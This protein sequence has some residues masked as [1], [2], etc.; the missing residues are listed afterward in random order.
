[1]SEY[2]GDLLTGAEGGVLY[3]ELIGAGG[4]CTPHNGGGGGPLE[5]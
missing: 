2:E 3:V 1:M 5:K 4:G